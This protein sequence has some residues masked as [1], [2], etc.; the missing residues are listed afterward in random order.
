M[1]V[2][3]WGCRGS[4]PVPMTAEQAEAK[5]LKILQKAVS[6]GVNLETN[7]NAFLHKGLPF[8]LRSTYG[9]NTSCVEIK[10]GEA[11]ILCDAGTGLREFGARLAQSGAGTGNTFHLFLSH[12]HWDHIQGFPFFIPAYIPGNSIVIHGCHPEIESVFTAQQRAPVF[13]VDFHALGADVS[14]DIMQPDVEYMV[15]GV[16]VRAMEQHHP[17][18]SYSYRFEKDGKAMV[19]ATDSE[20]KCELDLGGNPAV[21]FFRDTD[22][23]I[24]DTQYSYADACSSKEDWGHSN[25]IIGVELA[26]QANVKHLCMFHHDPSQDDEALDNFLTETRRYSDMHEGQTPL[27]ISMAYDTMEIEL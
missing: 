21:E 26:K 24:F 4:A 19:Y 6:R 16:S 14:F 13:P 23:V 3:I 2:R 5:A 10:G 7:L 1:I 20:H 15:A 22:M 8:H 27:H 9:G 25:N 12:P 17:G 18:S 11:Y